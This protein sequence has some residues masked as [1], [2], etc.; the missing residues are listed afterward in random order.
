MKIDVVQEFLTL[1]ALNS[2]SRQEA[3]VAD[4]IGKR[5]QEM[6]LVPKVDDT[7]ARSGSDTGNLVVHLPGNVPGPKILLGAHMDTISPTEGLVPI[8]RDGMI[9]SNGR[10][11]LGADDKAGIA[12]ILALLAEL[13]ADGLPHP[14]LIAVFTVQ[15]ELGLFGATHMRQDLDADFGYVLDGDGP[16]GTIVHRAP[17]KADLNLTI[18]GKAAHAGVC[19]ERGVNAIA[20]AA[21]AIARLTFGRHDAETTSNVGVISGGKAKNIVPDLV[22]V[23]IE[24]RGIAQ[25]RLEGEILKIIEVFGQETA[26]SGARLS[27]ERTDPFTAFSIDASHLLVTN[28]LKAAKALGIPSR[29][30]TSGGGMDA[31]VF[32]LR[33][34]PCVGLGIGI[35]EPHAPTEHIALTQLTQGVSFLK[36]LLKTFL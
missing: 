3:V 29:L 16:V 7:A 26:A 10:T 19:P 31:N 28:A 17:S 25:E 27:V 12:M 9:Y 4:H 22:E 8:V 20:V 6:G 5:L 34:L 2:P 35:Q 21:A 30:I 15:E 18:E 1:A 36:A 23:A 32:N 24:V 14:S 13:K 33:G 11:V